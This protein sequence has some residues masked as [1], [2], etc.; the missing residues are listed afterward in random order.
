MTGLTQSIKENQPPTTAFKGTSGYKGI[1]S[2]F[3][4][5]MYNESNHTSNFHSSLKLADV[6]PA[7]KKDERILKGTYRNVSILY[8]VSK[9]YER[10][11]FDQIST[12]INRYLSVGING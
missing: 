6:T 5:E 10:E 9:I 8:A 4:T 3:I 2:P 12:Y 7:H 1:I 11:M